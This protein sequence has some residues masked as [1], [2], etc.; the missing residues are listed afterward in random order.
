MVNSKTF[1]KANISFNICYFLKRC[2]VIDLKDKK[3]L[4]TFYSC[5]V[6]VT[7]YTF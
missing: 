5:F 4:Y 2:C 7:S 1:F 6:Y 3:R